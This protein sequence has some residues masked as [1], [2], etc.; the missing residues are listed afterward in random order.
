VEAIGSLEALAVAYLVGTYP[1]ISH[2][3]VAR[4]VAELRAQGLMVHTFSIHRASADQLLTAADRAAAAETLSIQPPRPGTIVRAQLRAIASKRSRWLRTLL[5]SL[6]VA[7]PGWRSR[8]WHVFYFAEAVVL[9]TWCRSRGVR[10]LH[11]HFGNAASAVVMLTAELAA[12]EGWSWSFTMHGP[13]EFDDVTGFALAEKVRRASVVPCISDY[14]RSQLMK[15]VEP[16]HWSK[17]HLVRCGIDAEHFAPPASRTD[18]PGFRLLSIG[19]LTRDKGQEHLLEAVARARAEG[20]PVSLTLLGEGPRRGALERLAV[21]LGIADVVA[22]PGAV[23]QNEIRTAYASADAFCL[24]SFAEGVPVVLMEAMAMELP[25]V[26][27][28]LMGIPELVEHMQTGL[29]I[30]PGRADVLAE[31][32]GHLAES[33][34]LRARLGKAGRARVSTAYRLDEQGRRLA[35]LFSGPD[36]HRASD[37]G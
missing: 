26:A 23:S 27:P 10:H 15:L 8:L 13:T 7:P 20:H 19:R 17:L 21:V 12:D 9:W 4:E 28:R 2:T 1:A 33:A 35:A 18:G 25:V 24:S 6:R 34:E 37:T 22:M 29:L 5:L 31:A 30:T 16:D 36:E 3:F 11:A 14:A 32:L